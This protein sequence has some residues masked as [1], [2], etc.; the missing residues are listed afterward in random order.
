M[1][2]RAGQLLGVWQINHLVW[3]MSVRHWAANT[4]CDDLRS[5]IN[6]FQLLEERN[7]ATL[8][9]AGRWLVEEGLSGLCDSL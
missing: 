9:I 3:C 5:W 6:T 4:K 1:T 8:T 7:G 2:Y